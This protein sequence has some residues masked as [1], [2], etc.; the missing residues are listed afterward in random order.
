MRAIFSA[1]PPAKRIGIWHADLLER[2]AREISREFEGS[3]SRSRTRT[4]GLRRA[5][6]PTMPESLIRGAASIR[7]PVCFKAAAFALTSSCQE[8]SLI[9]FTDSPGTDQEKERCVDSTL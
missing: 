5:R 7:M 2:R 6:S 8:I 4:A 9:V 1:T 3:L